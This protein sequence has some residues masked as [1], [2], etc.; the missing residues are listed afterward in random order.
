MAPAP[1]LPG[2]LPLQDRPPAALVVPLHTVTAVVPAAVDA[3]AAAAAGLQVAA[4][5]LALAA[6][7]DGEHL[8]RGDGEVACTWPPKPPLT[9]PAKLLPPWAPNTSRVTL[10]TPAG[11][12]NFWLPPAVVKT[13]PRRR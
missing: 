12:V 4:A 6:D 11:T 2:I 1:A 8:P 13:W 9:V 7:P 3:G 10:L 5:V